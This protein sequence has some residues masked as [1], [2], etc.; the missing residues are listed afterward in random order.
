M[1]GTPHHAS[2]PTQADALLVDE[3][4]DEGQDKREVDVHPHEPRR[5]VVQAG[6]VRWVSECTCEKLYRPGMCAG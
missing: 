2:L 1:Q 3:D 5:E 4:V 6:D